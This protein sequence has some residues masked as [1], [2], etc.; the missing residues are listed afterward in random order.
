MTTSIRKVIPRLIERGM[1]GKA[2][3][4]R[5]R[6]HRKQILLVFVEDQAGRLGVGEC[7]LHAA[8]PRA[9]IALI[10]DDLAP[11]VF[12]IEPHC[13]GAVTERLRR[14]AE[15]SNQAGITAAAW[16]GIEM[17]L[18]DLR[19]RQLG[20]PL[21]DL[22]GRCRDAVPVYAS[23]GLYGEG[24]TADDLAAEVKSWVDQGFD[25]VK[26]KVG[27]APLREDLRRV[28]LVREAV[29]P[30]VRLM[31]DALYNFD[32]AEALRFANAAAPYDITF[33]EA[34]VS[35][36]DVAG[37]AEVHRSSPIP[38][39]GNE[40]LAWIAPF[41]EL[42]TRHATH[43]VQFDLAACG[44]VQEGRRIAE[45]AQAF[46]RPATLHAASSAVLFA[47]SLHLACSIPNA[48]SVEYHM[49]HQWLWDL[50]PK[51]TFKARSGT[52][53]PPV[54][55]GHGVTLDPDSLDD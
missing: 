54:G 49:L 53:P 19:A 27:G 2:W 42:I 8:T 25:A 29:G 6:F 1:D 45:L 55:P 3:N 28:G 43:L 12:G 32:V 31:V 30:N 35:P 50:V 44:G 21:V 26:I 4:P 16:S 23:A 17:A 37:Q 15:M 34:P 38:V 46:H 39:C 33:F 36:F 52:L 5:T 41:R 24:K 47:A 7:W 48:H 14:S 13:A 10:E 11:L 18:Q 40:T 22:M 9:L 20:L 51:D